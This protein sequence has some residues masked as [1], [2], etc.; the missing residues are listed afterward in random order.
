MER[1]WVRWLRVAGGV[2]FLAVAVVTG[3]AFAGTP[4]AYID[5]SGPGPWL[6]LCAIPVPESDWT[7]VVALGAVGIVLLWP[8]RRR[9]EVDRSG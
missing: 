1:H 9:D 3:L 7:P 6:T 2:G 8:S 4:A 5:C